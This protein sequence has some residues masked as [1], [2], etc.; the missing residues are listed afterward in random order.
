MRTSPE[1]LAWLMGAVIPDAEG[2]RR[3]V[4]SAWLH[5]ENDNPVELLPAP[6]GEDEA[7]IRHPQYFT[8]EAPAVAQLPPGKSATDTGAA[9][10]NAAY[11]AEQA[12]G[13]L[14]EPFGEQCASVIEQCDRTKKTPS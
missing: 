2:V 14:P 9:D 1:H 13:A 10:D 12:R 5:D 8:G 3:T 6:A 7:R 4:K 11:W